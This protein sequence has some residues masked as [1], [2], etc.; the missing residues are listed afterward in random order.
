MDGQPAEGLRLQVP[1]RAILRSNGNSRSVTTDKDGRFRALGLVPG[2]EY[3]V[4]DLSGDHPQ[5]FA[6]VVVKS[7]ENK[8]LGNIKLEPRRE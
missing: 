3:W 1:G 2:Q 8:D 7:G 5:F 4:W 6:K